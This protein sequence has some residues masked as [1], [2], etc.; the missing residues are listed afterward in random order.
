VPAPLPRSSPRSRPAR[1]SPAAPAWPPRALAA[2]RPSGKRA[3]AGG[4][5]GLASTSSC[6]SRSL[7]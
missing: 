7:V 5:C 6:S 2:A 4:S 1:V 3:A